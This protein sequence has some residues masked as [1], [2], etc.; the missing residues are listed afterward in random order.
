MIVFWGFFFYNIGIQI[1]SKIYPGLWIIQTPLT[2]PYFA[3]QPSHFLLFFAAT[4]IRMGVST[5]L[6]MN[7]RVKK[8][9]KHQNFKENHKSARSTHYQLRGMAS[10]LRMR[11]AISPRQWQPWTAVSSL[12]GLISMA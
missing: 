7:I 5:V 6:F 9:R 2:G 8:R 11:T 10:T 1:I 12:L 3:L 4:I